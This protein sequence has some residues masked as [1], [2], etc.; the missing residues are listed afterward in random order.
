MCSYIK[1]KDIYLTGMHKTK[2]HYLYH[3]WKLFI[4]LIW[5]A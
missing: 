4:H 1:N 3:D 2:I 5:V